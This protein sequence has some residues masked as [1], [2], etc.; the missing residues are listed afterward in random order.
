MSDIANLK[1]ALQGKQSQRLFLP[2]VAPGTM[3]H[4]M[5]N[6]YYKTTEDYLFAIA[7]AMRE[8][9]KAIVDAGFILQIDDPDLADAWQ[10]H[11]EM[12]L[13]DYRKYQE[14]RIDAL[15]HALARITR[16]AFAFTCAGAAIMGRTST[17]CR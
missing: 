2:A 14:L 4:W 3:E 7:D 15:N 6:E 16:D 10:M 5:K 12:S 13:A 11:P 9:Y 8:E 17:T 1:A